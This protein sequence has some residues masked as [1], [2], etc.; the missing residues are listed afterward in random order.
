MSVPSSAKWP[1]RRT[2]MLTAI[3]LLLAMGSML[4]VGWISRVL[5]ATAVVL[6][7]VAAA[8]LWWFWLWPRGHSGPAP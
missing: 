8:R 6:A 4:S 2:L 1:H 7:L 3:A 5:A